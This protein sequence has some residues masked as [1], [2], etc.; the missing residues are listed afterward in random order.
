MGCSTSKSLMIF[1]K[2]MLMFRQENNQ[3]ETHLQYSWKVLRLCLKSLHNI[4]SLDISELTFTRLFYAKFKMCLFNLFY[5][6]N[7]V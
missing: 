3:L 4:S 1:V 2:N 5:K 7:N 6:R